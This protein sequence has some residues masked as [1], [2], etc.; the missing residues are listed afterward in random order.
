MESGQNV[1]FVEF[2]GTFG[3]GNKTEHSVHAETVSGI[4]LEL[5]YRRT[6]EQPIEASGVFIHGIIV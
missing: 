4:S 2:R 3:F 6:H 5:G 1:V